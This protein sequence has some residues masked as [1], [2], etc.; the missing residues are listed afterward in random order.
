[1]R[2][3][4]PAVTYSA[5]FGFQEQPFNITP[6]LRFLYA[7]PVYQ[8][9]YTSLIHGILGNRGLIVLLGEAG[10][11]KT[12]LL[13]KV[14]N[15]LDET[16]HFVFF[17]NTFLTFAELLSVLCEELGLSVKTAECLQ[18]LQALK[19]LLITRSQ[20]ARRVV[21][22]IDEAQVLKE[23]ALESLLL[24][25]DLE[26][27]GRSLLQIVLVGQPELE[28]KLAVPKLQQLKQR[29]STQCRLESLKEPE[30]GSYINHRLR[31]AGCNRPGL[32]PPKT[33]QRVAQ[34]STGIP[35]L[36]NVICDNALLLASVTAQQTIS[37]EIIEEVA[38]NLQLKTDIRISQA[39]VSIQSPAH[40]FPAL[41]VQD[42]EDDLPS[43]AR[44]PRI[45]TRVF[46]F[47]GIILSVLLV[48][49]FLSSVR[50]TDVPSSSPPQQPITP[51]AVPPKGAEQEV[52]VAEGDVPRLAVESENLKKDPFHQDRTA[53]RGQALFEAIA[54]KYPALQPFVW[55]LETKNPQLALF[56][57]LTEWA[58]LSK[59]E[60]VSIVLYVE[61]LVP[62]VRA[63][64]TTYLGWAET[65]PRY[66]IFRTKVAN[67]CSGC[68]TIGVGRSTLDDQGVL[69]EKIVVQ[70]DS[71][72]ERSDPRSR[73]VKASEF[74][75][76][77]THVAPR[78]PLSAQSPA[79][80]QPPRITRATPA[81][82]SKQEVV[83]AE[84][85][86]VRFAVEAESPQKEPLR[87]V[88]LLD[89]HE[90]AKG[91]TWTY[92]PHFDEGGAQLKEVKALVS[93]QDNLTVERA[94]RVRVKDVNRP[95]HIT[96]ASPRT[97]SLEVSDATVLKFSVEAAD[98]DTDDE[99][100]YTWSLDGKEVAQGQQWG[101]QVPST[102]NSQTRYVVKV[103][104]SDKEGLTDRLAWN[105]TSKIP[106][107]LPRSVDVQPQG[108][109]D[110]PPS[111][112]FLS[113]AEAR[114]WLITY[115]QALQEKNVDA[116]VK[117]G[118]VSDQKADR[119]RKILSRYNSFRVVFQ[120]VDIR[121]QGNQAVVAFSRVDT[122]DGETLPHPDRQVFTLEKT[123]DGRLTARV[124]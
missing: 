110:L 25:L 1:L 47:S 12:T 114:A 21:L 5:Y 27:E 7:T 56:L 43:P 82:K 119:I 94:W 57:P 60:Q 8:Q 45:S 65:D 117:L 59:E 34:Y 87:Y 91:K 24:L 79:V 36:I 120:D 85:K 77:P 123:A 54:K 41:Q 63:N 112:V 6:D 51:Q 44:T 105:V 61:S 121:S 80:R 62:V 107:S 20:K 35:R 48:I 124:Q 30:I 10:T 19:E 38:Y 52:A 11:G 28:R 31:V 75:Q 88:W 104:V 97:N 58:G 116:L 93:D 72:W 16:I 115:Q 74:R 55:G 81:R 122:I 53:E 69:F 37:P 68:W 15:D 42:D 78:E 118:V 33:V 113:E 86:K 13:R 101:F 14:I 70:G 32:F 29:I 49:A 111:P 4:I 23:E 95:P 92:Q 39:K 99:L 84:G 83:V 98:P 18:K 2:E 3:E 64:P 100:V 40:R 89:G 50:L 106:V 67:L 102:P 17:Y 108:K 9:V 90:R 109:E 73:G 103:Q 26:A 96:V 76:E 71:A 22:L 66:H 46:L